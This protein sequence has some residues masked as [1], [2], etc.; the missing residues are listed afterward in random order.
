MRKFFSCLSV[1]STS[2]G[3]IMFISLFQNDEK[4]LNALSFGTNGKTFFIILNL[5]NFIGFLFALFAERNKYRILL[6]I[7]SILMILT[8]LFLTFVGFYGFQE[9]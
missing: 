2:I 8:S 6:F 9:P 4:L 5:Y 3:F 7:F 1:I